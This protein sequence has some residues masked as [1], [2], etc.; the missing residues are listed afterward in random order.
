MGKVKTIVMG[1]LESEE[2]AR[3]KAEL[4]REQK[5]AEK[6]ATM[7]KKE[8][9]KIEKAEV[10]D[11]DSLKSGNLDQEIKESKSPDQETPP[12]DIQKDQGTKEP[13][14]SKKKVVESKYRFLPGKKY[15]AA[16]SLVDSSKLYPLTEAIDLVKK[17]SFS[18]FDGTVEV[19]YNITDKTLRGTVTLPHGTGKQIRIVI[20]TDELINQLAASPRIDF[21]VLVAS[22][23]M[24]PKL[25]RVAKILGPKGLMPNPKTNTIGDD[26]EQLVKTLSAS[27]QWKTQSDFPIIHAVIG[28]V[29]FDS[30]KLEE[31]F[32]ALTKSIGKDKIQS[33]FLKATMG[34][35][36]KVQI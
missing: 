19:H 30:K 2:A 6:E 13:K 24:M 36:I 35:A 12:S 17:T 26:P 16:K 8:S 18:S 9:L 33:V 5:R 31:N 20:A 21:D 29:S 25:A 4:K 22:P 7:V 11:T 23:D 15:A 14:K 27:L 10:L 1:D 32:S 3:K 28:K 34:P